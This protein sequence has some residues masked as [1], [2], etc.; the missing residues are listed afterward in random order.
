MVVA[1]EAAE[2]AEAAAD[3]E[4]AAAAAAAEFSLEDAEEAAA[5]LPGAPAAGAR[6]SHLRTLVDARIMAG[7][8]KVDPANAFF[9]CGAIEGAHWT[10]LHLMAAPAYRPVEKQH[11]VDW[12][13]EV[14]WC[15]KTSCTHEPAWCASFVC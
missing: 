10:A 7:F 14:P 2:A 1:A 12:T 6:T 11:F 5:A 15:E 13:S 8:D 4:A 9:R 3:A